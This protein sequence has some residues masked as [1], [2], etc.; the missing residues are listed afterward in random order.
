MERRIRCQKAAS[1]QVKRDKNLVERGKRRHRPHPTE[2][3]V[4][5]GTKGG[6]EKVSRAT[7]LK[8]KGGVAK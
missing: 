6:E 3:G 4:A 7:R 5:M 1:N 8:E 2:K